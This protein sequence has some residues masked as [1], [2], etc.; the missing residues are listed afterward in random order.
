MESLVL[1]WEI[2]PEMHV[3]ACGVYNHMLRSEGFTVSKG[4]V[5][6]KEER[7]TMRKQKCELERSKKTTLEEL[8]MELSNLM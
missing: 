7:E 8:G 5:K 2:A 3:V 4:A 6:S 1:G